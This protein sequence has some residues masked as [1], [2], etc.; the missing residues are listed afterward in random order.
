MQVLLLGGHGK[1]ALH[2]TPLLLARSWN[3]T[4]VIRNPEHESEILALGKGA[5][6]KL[7]VLLSSLDDVKS[8]GDA[9]KVL[10]AVDPDYVVWSAGTPSRL[11][12][13]N[14]TITQRNCSPIQ[15]CRSLL[16]HPQTLSQ[17]NSPVSFDSS[18]T[19]TPFS[20]WENPKAPAAKVVP[21]ARRR[22]MKSPRNI[23]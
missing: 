4:S 2:L 6:G 11:E 7:N 9:K 8:E 22:S 14:E 18:Y 5:K 1:V 19:L 21:P 17:T 13:D 15:P 16:S 20:P 23:S 10:D 3:V 12:S